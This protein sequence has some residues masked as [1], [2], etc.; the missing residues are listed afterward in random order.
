[1]AWLKGAET[2]LAPSPWLHNWLR[3]KKS[4][5]SSKKKKNSWSFKKCFHVLFQVITTN[6]VPVT[7]L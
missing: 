4:L 1:M 7:I 3:P 2:L 5:A 6:E